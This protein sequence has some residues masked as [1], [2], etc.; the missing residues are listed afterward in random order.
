MGLIVWKKLAY[1]RRHTQAGNG[2]HNVCNGNKG[3]GEAKLLFC[4]PAALPREQVSIEES[5]RKAEVN[6]DGRDDALLADGA[7]VI[8]QI[9]KF[10][11]RGVESAGGF[12]PQRKYRGLHREHRVF[13]FSVQ[14]SVFSL[15]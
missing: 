14:P 2:E 3:I 7:H 4:E 6:D 12:L 1:I 9:C 13:V 8:M 10:L 5:K 15:W 11:G